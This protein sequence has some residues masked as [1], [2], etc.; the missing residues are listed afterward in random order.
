[1]TRGA[2]VR[3]SHYGPVLPAWP[4]FSPLQSYTLD[5][6]PGPLCILLSP[7]TGAPA[8]L[9]QRSPTIGA[10]F[11]SLVPAL[12]RGA[13]SREEKRRGFPPRLS[14]RRRPTRASQTRNL[15]LTERAFHRGDL[16]FRP[17]HG[18]F[19]VDGHHGLAGGLPAAPRAAP[20]SHFAMPRGPEA[21]PGADELG[22]VLVGRA[23]NPPTDYYDPSRP[24]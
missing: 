13:P 4:A 2:A 10:P 7:Q 23:L 1:M 9:L 3:E 5:V 12:V 17:W 22:P 21:G 6:L 24:S 18:P 14:A 16:R 19:S 20:R 11:P 15:Q 8:W